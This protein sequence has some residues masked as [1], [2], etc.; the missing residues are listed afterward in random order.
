MT[1]PAALVG[2]LVGVLVP[3][4]LGQ[5]E[6]DGEAPHEEDAEGKEE[7]DD[8][9]VHPQPVVSAAQVA[10]GRVTKVVLVA[11]STHSR[12]LLNVALK[13]SSLSIF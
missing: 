7:D 5:V 10:D 4:V 6:S 8:D 1:I 3:R 12:S 9:D 11:L 13:V 2:G